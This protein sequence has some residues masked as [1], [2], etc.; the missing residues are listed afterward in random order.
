MQYPKIEEDNAF[1]KVLSAKGFS[2][3]ATILPGL[4]PGQCVLPS[5][6]KTLPYHLG[7]MHNLASRIREDTTL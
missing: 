5:G 2:S 6:L 4:K 1:S 7:N 3:V